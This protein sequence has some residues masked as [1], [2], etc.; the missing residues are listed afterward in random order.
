MVRSVQRDTLDERIREIAQSPFL[1]N[2]KPLP[3]SLADIP[4]SILATWARTTLY[5][6]ARLGEI[7][8]EKLNL[9]QFAFSIISL[10]EVAPWSNDMFPSYGSVSITIGKRLMADG[11]A[12][13][14]KLKGNHTRRAASPAMQELKELLPKCE[15]IFSSAGHKQR[16]TANLFAKWIS[17]VEWPTAGENSLVVSGE[18]V[19]R[20]YLR[21]SSYLRKWSKPEPKTGL[22]MNAFSAGPETLVRD[23]L[24]DLLL[25]SQINRERLVDHAVEMRGDLLK[26]YIPLRIR[27]TVSRYLEETHGGPQT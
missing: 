26:R 25:H 9:E 20:D 23:W 15:A 22:P 2:V 18:T 12:R 13:R 4:D 27:N 8:S 7:P 16:E 24:Q 10:L 17:A 5:E 1:S 21:G 14:A 11:L 19:R 3:R 6:I